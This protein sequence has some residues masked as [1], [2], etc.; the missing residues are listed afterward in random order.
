MGAQFSIF[1]AGRHLS[2]VAHSMHANLPLVKFA[3][4]SSFACLLWFY[5][6]LSFPLSLG[7]SFSLYLVTG[8]WKFILVVLKTLP[9][10]ARALYI[11][12][13]MKFKM[14]KYIRENSSIPKI[15]QE[16]VRKYPN[17]VAFIYEGHE[18]TFRAVDECS[19]AIAN[20]LLEN[21][22]QRDDVIALFMESRP[23]F[24]CFW[25]GMAK[26]GVVGALINFNLR[27]DSLLHCI[28][29]S[30]AKGLI[31]GGELI[32]AVKDIRPSLRHDMPLFCSGNY[33]AAVL[34]AVHLDPLLERCSRLP[35]PNLA[36]K[37]KGRLFLVYTSGTTG[38]PKAAV[39]VHSRYY[40]MASTLHMMFRL[41]DRDIIYDCLP[42]Y[43]TAGG[44]LGIGQTLIW[45]NTLVIRKK[46]SASNFWT[47]CVRYNCTVVQYIGE[48]CR[49]LLAQPHR[50]EESQHHVRLAYGNGLRPQIWEQFMKRFNVGQIGEFYGATEG[51]ANIVN[52]DNKVA[53][54]GFT[55]RI[56][57]FLYPVTL[58]KVD[59]LTGSPIRDSHGLCIQC[60]PGEPGELVG[61]IVKGDPIREFDGYVNKDATSKKI[62]Y[63]VFRKGDMAFLTGDMLIMDDCGYMYFKDRTGDTFR[64]RGENV[65][66]SEVEASISNI[67]KL[68][69][70]VVYGV[71]VPGVEGKAGM[72]AIVDGQHS[73]DLNRLCKDLGRSLPPY[74]RPVFIR[75]LE[76]LE[77][78]GT[79]KLKKVNLQKE[80]Y[81]PSIVK[82]RLFYMDSKSGG[83]VP[84]DQQV[85]SQICSGKIRM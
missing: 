61:K 2:R 30:E 39:V 46:F 8:G 21:G 11:L 16:T 60:Q 28:Q 24:V 48:I 62:A 67:V 58:I 63:D 31:F 77:A 56:A 53:A 17:K 81:N 22:Y 70:C 12:T 68:K 72:A 43:H 78:T 33:N 54:V 32:D 49:Y 45:G 40:Y 71:E 50:P 20:N 7:A 26:I 23:E 29:A 1:G 65:S 69:D 5:S 10:D 19:N 38:M 75:L 3:G 9:R 52:M 41:T 35:P 44:I 55:T 37:F 57:P 84:I 13:T 59:E 27:M 36:T 79:F 74:A 18:W 83:Y 64:W 82:D 66:T 14:K 80:G 4:F 73:I 34:P 76:E 51:N 85:Y 42:L 15:F 47:D 6:G 25:L